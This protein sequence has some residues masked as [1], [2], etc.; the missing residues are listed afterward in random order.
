MSISIQFEI[1]NL[2]YKI[3]YFYQ[4][5]NV[6]IGFSSNDILFLDMNT[7]KLIV[8]VFHKTM[9]QDKPYISGYNDKIILQYFKENNSCYDILD[10]NGKKLTNTPIKY[11]N[12]YL[13]QFNQMLYS[14]LICKNILYIID[15]ND[16]IICVIHLNFIVIWNSNPIIY[17]DSTYDHIMLL[18]KTSN[19]LYAIVDII[20]NATNVTN[21]FSIDNDIYYEQIT[22]G[23]NNGLEIYMPSSKNLLIAKIENLNYIQ[24]ISN[25]FINGNFINTT[26]IKNFKNLK[27]FSEI[28]DDLKGNVKLPIHTIDPFQWLKNNPV[29]KEI[30]NT[31][32]NTNINTNINTIKNTNTSNSVNLICDKSNYMDFIN[33]II[34]EFDTEFDAIFFYSDINKNLYNIVYTNIITDTYLLE[35]FSESINLDNSS[36]NVTDYLFT[37]HSIV[38]SDNSLSKR[39]FP[40][41]LYNQIIIDKNKDNMVVIPNKFTTLN[42]IHKTID[43]FIKLDIVTLKLDFALSPYYKI[44]ADIIKNL[45]IDYFQTVKEY[46]LKDPELQSNLYLLWDTLINPRFNT[47]TIST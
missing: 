36:K 24:S 41:S 10:L 12:N 37:T 28:L 3:Q 16:K 22:I 1:I 31:N 2:D 30:E 14:L 35:E 25:K 33:Y 7:K 11:K 17:N 9:V 27:T 23:F 43:L 34:D 29:S 4:L 13:I 38:L 19:N 46:L 45:G 47:S 6:Y 20:N 39:Y 40:M 26:L 44:S 42:F 5:F 21:E 18:V 8:P 15:P 32:K